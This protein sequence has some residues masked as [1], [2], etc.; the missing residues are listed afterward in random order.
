MANK[1]VM[2]DGTQKIVLKK[3]V[4][5]GNIRL[6]HLN[7]VLNPSLPNF[8][9]MLRNIYIRN[10]SLD[11]YNVAGETRFTISS[12]DTINKKIT[13]S[14]YIPN[15][16]KNNASL[17]GGTKKWAFVRDYQN[18][19]LIDSI[20]G[21]TLSYTSI[22]VGS[23]SASNVVS[24]YNPY[25]NY[26]LV[27]NTSILSLGTAGTWNSL[28]IIVGGVWQG[29]DGNYRMIVNGNNTA[30]GG[31]KLGMATS[32]DL[33]TWT[34]ANG[35]NAMYISGTGIFN[36]PG[37]SITTMNLVSYG[38]P[39]KL[40][41]NSWLHFISTNPT[42]GI[43]IVT[44]IYFDDDFTVTA[45]GTG[46]TIP[47]YPMD[48]IQQAGNAV[49]LNGTCYLYIIDRQTSNTSTW[50][51]IQCTIP[52]INTMV[53]TD[54]KIVLQYTGVD[55]FH[56]LHNDAC[57]AIVWK[58]V[59]YIIPFGTGI[60]NTNNLLAGNRELGM[61]KRNSNDT[62][63]VDGRSPVFTNP[64]MGNYLWNANLSSFADHV[65][66]GFCPIVK[67]TDLHVFMTFNGSSSTYKIAHT[68]LP[69]SIP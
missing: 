9:D 53:V 24:F 66:G 25:I 44:P 4:E 26:E 22:G 59:I 46:M 12:H 34:W 6:I 45:V 60:N 63:T 62:F 41:D 50:K 67:N 64:I 21:D 2:Y 13:V 15:E 52:D 37:V 38:N 7:D 65:G 3:D 5:S 31:T 57:S 55:N 29:T 27:S 43:A 20:I 30:G 51:L 39:I 33:D 47:S 11:N 40:A 68:R 69:I 19:L 10:T 17:Y 1:Y 23:F 56:G 14:P 48:Y 28:G 8:E 42:T 49:M 16:V 36:K 58:D 54:S 61:I 18:A 32:P 35:G